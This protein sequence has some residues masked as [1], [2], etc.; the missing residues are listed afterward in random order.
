NLLPRRRKRLVSHMKE[1]S[2]FDLASSIEIDARENVVDEDEDE[3]SF[4]AKVRPA[5]RLKNTGKENRKGGRARGRPKKTETGKVKKA[6]GAGGGGGRLSTTYTRKSQ[7]EAELDYENETDGDEGNGDRSS[8]TVAAVEE[9]AAMKL[10]GKAREE[11]KRLRHLFQEVDGWGL[12]FEE[13][14]GSS[15]RMQ[16]AR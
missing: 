12:E 4:H 15:D 16:D 14:T 13:V 10:G 6:A 3:L 7:V 9:P 1:T 11:M 5:A 2:I 8:D